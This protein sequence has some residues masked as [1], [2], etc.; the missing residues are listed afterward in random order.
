MTQVNSENQDYKEEIYTLLLE[1]S[2]RSV[3]FN[4]ALATLLIIDLY[5]SVFRDYSDLFY[6]LVLQQN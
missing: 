6:S 4:I 5:F 1:S 2:L 3:P